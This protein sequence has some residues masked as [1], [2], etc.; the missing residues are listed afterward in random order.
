MVWDS[1]RVRGRGRSQF[2]D[3]S[4]GRVGFRVR[5]GVLI[6]VGVMVGVEG[7]IAGGVD[8]VVGLG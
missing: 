1:Y 2:M 3:W 6:G 7:Y 5:A 4:R 8:V